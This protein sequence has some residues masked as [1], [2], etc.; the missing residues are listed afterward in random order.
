MTIHKS[1]GK[2]LDCAVVNLGKKERER[3]DWLCRAIKS[4]TRSTFGC[5]TMLVRPSL[6]DK[7]VNEF[8]ATKVGRVKV[9][10]VGQEY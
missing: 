10:P 7:R 5:H 2:T 4:S 8:A 3:L 6:Q 9:D 1:Q